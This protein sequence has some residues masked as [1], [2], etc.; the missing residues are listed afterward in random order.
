MIAAA[1]A[2]RMDAHVAVL[3]GYLSSIGF[4]GRSF[5]HMDNSTDGHS[6]FQHFLCLSV[7]L[8][9]FVDIFFFVPLHPTFIHDHHGLQAAPPQGTPRRRRR[10]VGVVETVT[11]PWVVTA[12]LIAKLEKT[13]VV[14]CGD[15]SCFS[16]PGTPRDISRT[17]GKRNSRRR[18]TYVYVV[19]V[20]TS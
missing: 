9:T 6:R 12:S 10:F 7:P 2:A 14:R 13:Y 4:A 18:S 16:K 17:F 5:S 1:A 20:P 15:L 11:A 8:R 19:P 3:P